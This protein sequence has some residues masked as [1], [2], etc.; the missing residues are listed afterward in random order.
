MNLVGYAAPL[1]LIAATSAFA[2][3]ELGEAH[4]E[5]L[6][7]STRSSA[8]SIDRTASLVPALRAHAQ[9]AAAGLSKAF[10]AAQR[11]AYEATRNPSHEALTHAMA[12]A[13]TAGRRVGFGAG[14]ERGADG[15]LTLRPRLMLVPP[16]EEVG[17]G[18]GFIT[19]H[20]KPTAIAFNDPFYATS[21]GHVAAHFDMT[22]LDYENPQPFAPDSDGHFRF[23]D[24]ESAL[25]TL[26][27]T[28]R[29]NALRVNVA[30]S[31]QTTLDL[32]NGNA[33]AVAEAM[34]KKGHG[35]IAELEQRYMSSLGQ[36]LSERFLEH[37]K[38]QARRPSHYPSTESEAFHEKRRL[39]FAA[40]VEHAE[41]N[42]EVWRRRLLVAPLIRGR[43]AKDWIRDLL[44]SEQPRDLPTAYYGHEQLLLLGTWNDIEAGLSPEVVAH[45]L[46]HVFVQ[47]KIG[48]ADTR[49]KM[50]LQEALADIV[51]RAYLAND[52]HAFDDFYR[53][54]G[55]D[56]LPVEG[57]P[58]HEF[59]AAQE[60]GGFRSEAFLK[61]SA[62]SYQKAARM[63]EWE[64][65]AF[66]LH[67][68]ALRSAQLAEGRTPKEAAR[69]A[70]IEATDDFL[71]VWIWALS[72]YQE[73]DP[74][75]R[76]LFIKGFAEGTPLDRPLPYVAKELRDGVEKFKPEI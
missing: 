54:T 68:E 16:T 26:G 22:T 69:S 63:K 61:K 24:Q 5:A 62:V 44:I 19:S 73:G 60:P 34:A 39:P 30:S 46:T 71:R 56:L 47:D 38:R 8:A 42:P 21:N 40:M 6:L 14:Y 23:G 45:E 17:P 65:G 55:G 76:D 66:N 32:I 48:H 3:T 7:G 50:I 28:E 70:L 36:P 35:D 10:V 20:A 67:Y 43:K 15:T 52:P 59:G 49:S 57:N 1:I 18:I 12:L 74:L 25:H 33:K 41:A 37:L 58:L 75:L 4:R 11:A 72:D 9:A 64:L 13:E 29:P 51:A 31:L 2:L 27:E 53:T